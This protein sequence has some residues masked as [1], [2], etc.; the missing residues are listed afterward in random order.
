MFQDKFEPE[1]QNADGEKGNSDYIFVCPQ[2]GKEISP[3]SICEDCFPN[4]G[5]HAIT[6]HQASFLDTEIYKIDQ[7]M[8]SNEFH[9]AQILEN[10]VKNTM[11]DS[12]LEHFTWQDFLYLLN[13]LSSFY[14]RY[15][16]KVW[17]VSSIVVFV[18]VTYTSY[19]HF[20]P[21]GKLILYAEKKDLVFSYT[22]KPLEKHVIEKNWHSEFRGSSYKHLDFTAARASKDEKYIFYRK[23]KVSNDRET[24]YE[25]STYYRFD[26]ENNK[27]MKVDDQV[28]VSF[29]GGSTSISPNGSKAIYMRGQEG[30]LVFWNNGKKK[31]IDEMVSFYLV[32]KQTNH[33]FYVKQQAFNSSDNQSE[34]YEWSET[35]GKKMVAEKA[36]LQGLQMDSDGEITV[37]FK[38]DQSIYCKKEDK[39]TKRISANAASI[40]SYSGEKVY[41]TVPT[42]LP[43]TYRDFVK[44]SL[45]ESDKKIAQPTSSTDSGEQYFQKTQRDIIRQSF[46]KLITTIVSDLY[47]FDG[48]KSTLLDKNIGVSSFYQTT[49]NPLLIYRKIDEN[50]LQPLKSIDF[51]QQ[52]IDISTVNDLYQLDVYISQLLNQNSKMILAQGIKK[53]IIEQNF[54]TQFK[55]SPNGKWIGFIDD[56][57]DNTH[58]PWNSFYPQSGK[59][60]KFKIDDLTEFKPTVVDDSVTPNF[61]FKG[62][63]IFYTKGLKANQSEDLYVNGK[64]LLTNADVSMIASTNEF[65]FYGLP[66]TSDV[67]SFYGLAKA[68]RFKHLYEINGISKHELAKN[69]EMYVP[70]K[71]KSILYI[72]DFKIT[73][74]YGKLMISE[75]KNKPILVSNR[76]VMI[77]QNNDILIYY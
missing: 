2:C 23:Q 35:L 69:V 28:R 60:K 42:N 31:T 72:K 16:K 49:N 63:N 51:K 8:G 71:D 37:Y 15:K 65:T 33:V 38:N 48:K 13:L 45:E 77:F 34:I 61:F 26:V 66:Q 5:D 24:G 52:K 27:K 19:Q 32:N 41:Y 39:E 64:K 53:G 22:K 17:L 4:G 12:E 43:F 46:N 58:D 73:E 57:L 18:I 21:K 55:V 56:S 59:L 75:G 1:K 14:K 62:N 44:D 50:M 30:K 76:A 9:S 6:T 29:T 3:S 20:S 11:D 67:N 47:Y 54:G 70:L 74:G 25:L 68:S 10:Q 40:L 7:D 36:Q